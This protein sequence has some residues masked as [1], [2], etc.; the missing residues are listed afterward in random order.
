MF[1]TAILCCM[2]LSRHVFGAC[3]LALAGLL[4][5]FGGDAFAADRGLSVSSGA[6]RANARAI[7]T[8][9]G[10]DGPLREMTDAGRSQAGLRAALARLLRDTRAGDRVFVYVSGPGVGPALRRCELTT[11]ARTLGRQAAQV[12][13]VVE[14]PGAAACATGPAGLTADGRVVVLSAAQRGGS[15]SQALRGCLARPGLTANPLAS[16]GD[17][18]DCAQRAEPAL[19]RPRLAIAG[20]EELPLQPREPTC[21]GM[22]VWPMGSVAR[23]P[24]PSTATA[25]ALSTSS[26]P[27]PMAAA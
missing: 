13:M 5:G 23:Q 10:F 15:L 3:T 9:L 21:S 11:A 20:N 7:Y 4:G 17:L 27:R 19:G 12:V 22:S 1:D 16:F 25:T 18:F 2:N 26:V 14:A 24:G 6:D 8:L